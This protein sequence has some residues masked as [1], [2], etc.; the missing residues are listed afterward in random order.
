MKGTKTFPAIL[1]LGRWSQRLVSDESGG[2]SE[3]RAYA[4]KR[5]LQQFVGQS[6]KLDVLDKA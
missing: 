3:G 4:I 1:D 2:G 5:R 6:S